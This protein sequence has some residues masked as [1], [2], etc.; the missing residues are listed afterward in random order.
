MYS[1]YISSVVNKLVRKYN[2]RDPYELCGALG[3]RIRQKD[4]GADI[5]AYYFCQSRIRNIII[6]NRVSAPIQRILAAHELGH[7]RLHKKIAMLK[8]FHEI[9]LFNAICP[10]EYQANL[11][12]AELLVD[13]NELLEML[14]DENKSFFG[15]A[16]ELGVPAALLDFKFRMLKQKGFFIEAPYIANGDFLKYDIDGCFDAEY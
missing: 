3:I 9:E 10:M 1:N 5:K 14:N 4:L 7:D 16:R 15:I 6:N 8:G 11:F 12:A 13:E 2:T